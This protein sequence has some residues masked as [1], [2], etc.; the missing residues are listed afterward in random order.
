MKKANLIID[1]AKCHGCNNCFI[2]CKDEHWDNDHPPISVS[3]PRHGHRWM[4][5]LHIERGQYP[6][7]DVCYLP[8]PCM[9]CEAAPCL[10]AASDGAVYRRED[11]IVIIDPVKSM[12]QQALVESCPY[13]A[14]FW[15]EEKRI[16]Q[17]CTMC[18]HLLDSGWDQPRCSMSC[19]TGAMEFAMLDAPDM[20]RRA[21]EEGLEA[22]HSEHKSRPRVWYRNLHRFTKCHIAGSVAMDFGLECAVDAL[23]TITHEATKT[24]WTTRTNN[25][26]NF[27]LDGFDRDSGDYLIT[28]E[29]GGTVKTCVINLH[30][31]VNIG[32]VYL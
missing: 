9:H 16:P 26:G 18:A 2:S 25:Y 29:L 28:V 23:V 14:I 20:E 6:L 1:V 24:V 15:N 4:D 31:S 10:E 17:K 12:G 30:E 22:F 5:I 32:V 21:A 3:T 7:Q 8:K 27:K 11:G 19:P 13:G